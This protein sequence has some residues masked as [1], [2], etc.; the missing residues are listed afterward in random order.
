MILDLW[1]LL[2]AFPGRGLGSASSYGVWRI[3]AVKHCFEIALATLV[4]P[5]AGVPGAKHRSVSN[6]WTLDDWT[7]WTNF[8][9]HLLTFL[10]TP[11]SPKW[12]RTIYFRKFY[13]F[14]PSTHFNEIFDGPFVL[15]CFDTFGVAMK[16][17]KFFP[18]MTSYVSG[19]TLN[20]THS[21]LLVTRRPTVDFHQWL[22]APLQPR[23]A[24]YAIKHDY[25]ACPMFQSSPLTARM[26]LDAGPPSR[27]TDLPAGPTW[28][29]SAFHEPYRGDAICLF[30]EPSAMRGLGRYGDQMSDWV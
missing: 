22:L 18:E 29:R 3:L 1:S 15:Q 21:L 6:R 23:A 28:I 26:P 30:G 14:L 10:V 4:V 8:R 25:W 5:L 19:G 13:Y 16:P 2:P 27:L 20:P 24:V 12:P 11:S 17:V 7:S 9:L